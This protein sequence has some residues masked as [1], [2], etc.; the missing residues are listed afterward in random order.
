[1]SEENW[2][3]LNQAI[4][5]RMVDVVHKAI[6]QLVD[7]TEEFPAEI[8]LEGIAAVR[9]VPEAPGVTTEVRGCEISLTAQ[10][11]RILQNGL[12]PALGQIPTGM[13]GVVVIQTEYLP[14]PHLFRLVLAAMSDA[15][16]ESVGDLA[17][18][19]V[20]PVQYLTQH[21]TPLFF[22]NPSFAHSAMHLRAPDLLI[23]ETGAEAW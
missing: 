12:L 23:A 3:S 21:R 2:R 15:E 5:R 19:L 1:M 17:G 7:T 4:A 9:L 20:L 11:R 13:P 10:S 18:I 14:P 8:H 6:I 22:S 16:P